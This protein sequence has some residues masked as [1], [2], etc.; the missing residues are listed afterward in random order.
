MKLDHQKVSL[1]EKVGYSLGDCSVNFV[2]QIMLV[3]QLG[4]YTDVFGI[5]ATAAGTI[6]L[7]AR[8]IDAFV[9]PLVGIMSDRTNTKWGKY[10]PWVL[11]TALPFGLFFFLAF[12]TPDVSEQ[13]KIIYAGITYT[14]LMAIYS[15]NNTPYSALHG[16]MSSNI[17]ERTSIGS[18]RFVL[19]MVASLIVQGFTLPLVDKLGQGDDQK[20]W[21][22]AIGVLALVSIVFFIITFLSTKERITPPA[23]QKTS[24]K[25]DI[26]DLRH[27]GPWFSMFIVTLFIFTTLSLWGGGMYYFF[28]YY[29]EPEAI[30]SFLKEFNLVKQLD[31]ESSMMY[32]IMDAFGLLVL[33]DKSNAFSV[34]FSF[35][36]MVGQ[37]F[38]IVGVLTMSSFLAK[39]FGKRNTFI[40]CLFMTAIFT[41]LFFF[42]PS[43]RVDLAFSLNILKSI[44]YAPTIPL[45]WAMMGDVADYSEWKYKRRATGFV[46][47]G[48][49]F[50][51]KAGL[52]FGGALCGWIVSIYG[53]E[54]NAIQSP[55]AIFGIRLT[56]SIVPSATFMVSVISLIF[57][58]ITKEFNIKMQK[59]L[60]E[61]REQLHMANVTEVE[62]SITI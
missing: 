48:I 38:T 16:V 4:F 30:F 39:K 62:N 19:A 12:T 58:V 9:D 2:F 37:F 13:Y 52:G 51:L 6:L 34:G 35:F 40:V 25:Q 11:W 53:Y 27:N 43:D 22:M 42:V 20:G 23:T 17:D 55:D 36:N 45:L 1:K 21:S 50:A 33:P 32:N 26:K 18:V 44:F 10:R 60:S 24:I 7:M 54:P 49:V 47:S 31:Q 41:G 46:F 28:S 14:L 29:M 57:Y 61:R 59:D 56:A 8:I 5:K 15:L 3:F